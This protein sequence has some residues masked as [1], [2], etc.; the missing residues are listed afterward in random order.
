MTKRLAHAGHELRSATQKARSI[1]S[2]AGRGRFFLSAVTCC[3]R[4][5]FSITRSARR[6]Q[7]TRITRAPRETRKTRT[8]SMAAEFRLVPPGTQAGRKVLDF[9]GGRVLTMDNAS[10]LNDSLRHKILDKRPGLPTTS[11]RCS[12]KNPFLTSSGVSSPSDR[13]GLTPRSSTRE[14]ADTYGACGVHVESIH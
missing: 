8:R 2:S 3:R 1:S 7:I 14:R 12:T 4:A 5:R 10:N 9:A 11:E 13:S 6:R